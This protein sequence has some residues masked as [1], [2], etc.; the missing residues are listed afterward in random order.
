VFQGEFFSLL[1]PSG[2]GKTTLLRM[3]AGFEIPSQGKIYIDGVEMDNSTV[4]PQ[5]AMPSEGNIGRYNDGE[6]IAADLDEPRFSISPKSA[7]WVLTEYNNQNDPANFILLGSEIATTELT[8]IGVCSTTYTLDQGFPSGGSYSGPGVSGTNFNASVAGVGTHQITYSYTDITGCSNIANKNII[9][10]A[11]PAA[12]TG[13]NKECCELNIVDLEATGTNL[14]WYTDAGLTTLVGTGTPFATGETTAGVY[15]Y[16]VTQTI[17]SCES[18]ATTISLTVLNNLT[19]DTHPQPTAICE[20]EDASFTVDVT[21]YNP[22]YQW[23]ED[24]VN[25]SDGGI[26]GGTTSATLV[27]TNPGIAKNGKIYRCIVTTSCGTSPVNSNTALLTVTVLPVATFSYTGTPYCPTATNPSPTF[28]GGGIAGTFSSTAGLVFVNV[29][30]GQVDLSAST[31][32]DYIVTNTIAAAGG[33][34]IVI[35][36]SPISIISDLVWTGTV[37]TDWNVTG[38]W[39]CGYIPNSTTLVQIP[40][41]PNKPVLSSGAIGTVNNIVIDNGSSLT[42]TGNTIQISGTITNNGTLDAVAGI[43]EMNGSVAQIIGSDVFT[44][45]TIKDLI[46]NNSAGVTLQGPLNISGIVDPQSG[47]LSSDGYLI[48]LSTAAQ[49]GLIDG[50]GAGSVT[51]DVTMQ[52]Y[53]SSGY[54]YKYFSSPFQSATVNDFADDLTLGAFTFFRYDESRTSS[55]WVSYHTP[56]TNPLNLMEGYSVNFGSVDAPNTVDVTGV[57][58]NGNVSATLYNNNNTYT[59]GFNL[60]GNPYPSPIDWDAASGWTK[61]NIDDAVYY[62]RASTTDQYGGTYS[63]YIGGVS[64]DGLATNVIPSM[65]GFFIHVSDGAFPVTGTLAMNNSVRITDLTHSFIKSKGAY[66]VPLLRLAASF[67]DDPVSTDP[68]LIYFD[69]K[70]APEFDSQL[71]ALKLFNT[72]FAVPNLFAVTPLGKKLSINALPPIS[73][74]FCSVPLGLKLNKT[75]NIIIKIRDVD[76]SLSG[77]RIYLSD[78][79]AGTEQDLLPD[80]EFRL[81]LTPGEYINRFILNFSNLT[82]AIN[83]NSDGSNLITI[84]SYRGILKAEIKSLPEKVGTIKVHN[85]T[86]QVLFIEKVYEAGYHEFNPGIKDGIYIVSFISGTEMISKM[87]FIK[88]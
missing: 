48:L 51:G 70:A 16:Y 2:C 29:L 65:Q 12:P 59:Q 42:I 23:Q 69:E 72:D 38:N 52:R 77:M 20:G 49:T 35:E 11:A 58:N 63:S 86:G 87:I 82:T 8:S 15:T 9:V 61:T 25:I 81:Y 40:D 45:N 39:S 66:P 28:S 85:L 19:I 4:A 88:N 46:I 71:D 47:N 67:S 76:E 50:S 43:V 26:Y 55:G 78:I 34:G 18:T 30:T 17:N 14:Q 6:Y 3:L 7:G 68:V 73:D 80:N 60:A 5:T 79:V 31:P 53:L 75:G 57:V 27:L 22:A 62:F 1:G 44:T 56:T 21:G 54:G 24:G 37:S 32:G 74:D 36:T 33:C 84:Y 64:S 41:V 83:D 13:P 10:T